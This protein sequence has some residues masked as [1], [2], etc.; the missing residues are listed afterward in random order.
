MI[1]FVKADPSFTERVEANVKLKQ[2]KLT[3]EF[4][5]FNE[6]IIEALKEKFPKR[7][8][9]FFDEKPKVL[10]IVF[11]TKEITVKKE[12]D[13]LFIREY[14]KTGNLTSNEPSKSYY[15]KMVR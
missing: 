13:W 2:G 14:K 11:K 1:K 3:L 9:S 7:Q 15:L 8:T 4:P 10:H 12:F 5:I 6:E